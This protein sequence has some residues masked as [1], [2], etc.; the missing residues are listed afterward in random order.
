M[1]EDHQLDDAAAL[2]TGRDVVWKRRVQGDLDQI[3]GAVADSLALG[4][5]SV[6]VELP[7]TVEITNNARPKGDPRS[8]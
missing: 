3:T 4:L 7:G 1:V 5:A 6:R 2:G 8:A